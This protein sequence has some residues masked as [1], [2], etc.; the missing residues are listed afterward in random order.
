MARPLKPR[1]IG[2]DLPA[3]Y[4]KPQGIPLV[5]LAE[6]VLTLD[7]LEALRHVDAD[8]LD[9]TAAAERMGVSRSTLSR[10]LAEARRAVAEALVNGHA[11]RIE[12]GVV[13]RSA[14]RTCRYVP[15]REPEAG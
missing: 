15:K 8:G 5:D 6:V 14:P 11:L 12:G 9:Q 3:S 13:T 7:G 1:V 10:I 4:F 2:D